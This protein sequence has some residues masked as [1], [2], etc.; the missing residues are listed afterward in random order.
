MK[1]RRFITLLGSAAA[2]PVAA[3]SQQPGKLPT[4]GYFGS[5]TPLTDSQWVAPSVPRVFPELPARC[6]RS[7]I[8]RQCDTLQQLSAG[9]FPPSP[10][11]TV[12]ESDA[13]RSL[14]EMP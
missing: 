14:E 5:G 1:R 2:W 11:D 7:R 13:A 4:I 9:L 12:D 6:Y 10:V 3:Q 8:G